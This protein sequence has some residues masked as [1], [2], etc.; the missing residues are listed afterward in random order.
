[1]NIN[2]SDSLLSATLQKSCWRYCATH[3]LDYAAAIQQLAVFRS[4][5]IGSLEPSEFSEALHFVES[6]DCPAA[7]LVVLWGM[8]THLTCIFT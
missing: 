2:E 7:L 1:L 4:S 3:Y 6:G 8:M 5:C